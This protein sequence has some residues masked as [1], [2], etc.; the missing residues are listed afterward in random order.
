MGLIFIEYLTQR[1]F[2]NPEYTGS[3]GSAEFL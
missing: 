1:E 2:L 3:S